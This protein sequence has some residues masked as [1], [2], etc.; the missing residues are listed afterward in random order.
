MATKDE[1]VAF[2]HQHK[3]DDAIWGK[4]SR[5]DQPRQRETLTA[6]IT[7]RFSAEEAGAIRRL[8]QAQQKSYSD[9]VREAVRTYTQPMF[10]VKGGVLTAS[11][12]QPPLQR[13]PLEVEVGGNL[14][15]VPHRHRGLAAGR[16]GR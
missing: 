7:V 11:F 2:Y 15:D 4:A 10:S 9:V 1:D 12:A 14:L 13:K 3:D 5:R 6:T 8:S 16:S